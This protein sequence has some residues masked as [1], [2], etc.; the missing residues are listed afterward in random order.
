MFD[1]NKL[2]MVSGFTIPQPSVYVWSLQD[3]SAPNAGRTE[4]ALMH[5]NLITKKRKLQLTWK[6]KDTSV[7][8]TILR[9]F[10]PEYVS[11]RYFDMLDNEYQTRTFY[12]GDKT[13]PVKM[14]QIGRHLIETI[15]FDIIER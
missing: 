3:V 13:A 2:I 14:W 12:T 1:N 10:D 7:A 9:A 8:S 15:Y 11:V 6:A 5:K 4:D